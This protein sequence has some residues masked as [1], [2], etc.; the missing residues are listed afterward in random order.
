MTVNK[1]KDTK[2]VVRKKNEVTTTSRQ[3]KRS[4]EESV[5]IPDSKTETCK[6]SENDCEVSEFLSSHDSCDKRFP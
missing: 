2:T 4:F 5:S 1:S 6:T 3:W